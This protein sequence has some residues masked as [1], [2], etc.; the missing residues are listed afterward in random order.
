MTVACPAIPVASYSCVCMA[1]FGRIAV[2][3]K[4][5]CWARV[6]WNGIVCL[7]L[8]VGW[9]FLSAY[10]ASI[11]AMPPASS[12]CTTTLWRILARITELQIMFRCLGWSRVSWNEIVCLD[13]SVDWCLFKSVTV[14]SHFIPT[15]CDSWILMTFLRRVA[16]WFKGLCWARV[17]WNEIVC[18]DLCVDCLY[19]LAKAR[20]GSIPRHIIP[21]ASISR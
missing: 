1:A 2:W 4:G 11:P 20:W 14:A 18:L 8:C 9:F 13:L 7:D 15:T 19:F 5:L 3:F 21:R 17:G 6:G 16:V 10:I 12:Y